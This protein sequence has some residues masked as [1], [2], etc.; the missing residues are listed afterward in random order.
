M[1]NLAKVGAV[2]VG[3]AVGAMASIASAATVSFTESISVDETYGQSTTIVSGN[4]LS[5]EFTALEDL[6]VQTISLSA[7]GGSAGADLNN[8]RFG[9]MMPPTQSLTVFPSGSSA[10]GIGFL[11][12]GTFTAGQTF[13]IFVDE[14]VDGGNA[15]DVQ[16]T[17][18]FETVAPSP[19]P[20]PASGALLLAA[21]GAGALLRRRRG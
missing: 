15:N 3:V 4:D 13:Q 5:F 17:L 14:A 19:V 11:P 16:F 18:S 7:T 9:F 10:A 2:A 21:M 8:I 12:G 1:M 6:E 20:L